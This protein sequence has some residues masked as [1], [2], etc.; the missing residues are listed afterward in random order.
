LQDLNQAVKKVLS[1]N[2]S[3][4]R[5]EIVEYVGYNYYLPKKL[6]IWQKYV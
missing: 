1:N 4:Y 5:Y 2:W 3:G 6:L